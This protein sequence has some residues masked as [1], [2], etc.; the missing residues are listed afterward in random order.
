MY[1][2]SPILINHKPSLGSCEVPCG[3]D[4]F[5]RFE[6]YWIQADTQTDRQAKYRLKTCLGT[7]LCLKAKPLQ[8]KGNF[9]TIY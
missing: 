6:V 5:S 4:R 2:K 7:K 3:P 8:N 1:A 9:S